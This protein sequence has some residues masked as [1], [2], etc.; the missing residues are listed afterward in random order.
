MKK[1]LKTIN[2]YCTLFTSFVLMGQSHT[3]YWQQRADY[4]IQIKV[5]VEKYSFTGRETII[6]KNNSPDTLSRVFFHLYFNAF[7]PGS[8]MDI[9]SRSITDP[10]SRV[11]DRIYL[12]KDKD[13]GKLNLLSIK[14]NNEI[15]DFS[16][17]GTI[18]EID[19]KKN[20]LPGE[21]TT[22]FID[23]NGQVPKQI[24]R[25]GKE[26][27]EGVALSMTQWY[28]KIA[29]YDK[30]GWHADSYIGREFYGVWGDFDVS[31]KIDSSYVV[32]GTGILQNQKE[33][34]DNK[35]NGV[36]IEKGWKTWR[37]KA[38]NVHDFAWAADPEYVQD[39]FQKNGG[40]LL[41]F[42]YKKTLDKK[43]KKF[44][45]ELQP[46]TAEIFEYLNQNIGVYPFK[47]FSVIQGGD[48]GMEY[49]MCTL[50]TGKREFESLVGVVAHEIAHEWFYFLLASN[51]G[52]HPWMDEGFAEYF[53]NLVYS[54]VLNKKAENTLLDSYDIVTKLMRS[55][56][57]KP[58]SVHADRYEY[59]AVYS[60]NSYSKGAVFLAQLKYIIGASYFD[61]TLKTYFSKWKFKHPR[62]SDFIRIAEKTSKINLDWY[63]NDWTRTTNTIDY[64]INSV[65][66]NEGSVL[67]LERLGLM[68][69]PVEVTVVYS[70]GSS[71]LYYIPIAMMRGIR[72][73]KKEEVLLKAWSWANPLYEFKINKPLSSVR[74]VTIDAGNLTADINR[75]NNHLVLR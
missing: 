25:S 65:K 38:S 75:D 2:F 56:L 63:L 20:I 60:I 33:T 3:D 18:A 13:I 36:R 14:Q 50:I 71:E 39:T 8:D 52:K 35:S 21:S 30:D 28:P 22:F 29:E 54:H 16:V 74:S 44:W 11:G 48:G 19:L 53:G 6:Y 32:A 31:I 46:L 26:N 57:N 23:F 34:N 72:E 12:L 43:F 42:Y 51:E 49:P 64:K 66:E 24:R 9:R 70:D 55:P 1:T 67:R 40:P 27:K 73:L 37:F 47:E 61:K 58:M 62:P 5:A 41:R 45:K 59:N 15:V 4:D 68:P 17:N 69:M 10:D 7:Q